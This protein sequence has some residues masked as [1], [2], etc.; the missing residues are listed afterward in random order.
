M[1]IANGIK[2]IKNTSILLVN[3]LVKRPD[4]IFKR[5]CPAVILANNRTPNEN[6]LAM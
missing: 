5:V 3:N 2:V 4:S 1:K 6:A